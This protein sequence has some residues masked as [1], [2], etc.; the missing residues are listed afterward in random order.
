MK[1]LKRIIIL[2]VAIAI[3]AGLGFYKYNNT[4][5]YYN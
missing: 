2:V 5:T 4:V 1:V 3:V